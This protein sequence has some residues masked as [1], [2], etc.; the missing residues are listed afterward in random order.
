VRLQTND[1]YTFNLA[2]IHV[3]SKA[4]K[5][6]ELQRDE[7]MGMKKAILEFESL[8]K[9]DKTLIVGDLNY[10]PFESFL[11][12]PFFFNAISSK[13]VVSNLLHRP[14]QT[15]QYPYYYNPMWN[16]LGD[17]DY[18]DK[19]EKVGG[20]FYWDTKDSGRYHWNLIDGV[21]LSR[22]IMDKLVMDSLKIVTKINAKDLVHTRPLGANKSY[23]VD[24]YSDHLPVKFTINTN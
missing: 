5:T 2:A 3:Y 8:M 14:L 16:L 18:L 6:D 22:S 20:T 24:G 13:S 9:E 19:G 21:L 17:Y 10:H 7:N 15:Q 23:L 11:Q 4:G 1:G 12:S